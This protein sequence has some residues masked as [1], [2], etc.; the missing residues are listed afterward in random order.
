MSCVDCLRVGG[1][2]SIISPFHGKGSWA[3]ILSFLGK[4]AEL[5]GSTFLRDICRVSLLQVT[6]SLGSSYSLECILSS[7]SWSGCLVIQICD[8]HS[9][10]ISGFT[11]TWVLEGF[12]WVWWLWRESPDLTAGQLLTFSGSEGWQCGCHRMNHCS[13][14]CHILKCC[15]GD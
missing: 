6:G 14:L 12:W 2:L 3:T 8:S 11:R 1:W 4:A 7:E 5:G 10:M 15:S 13:F 9:M